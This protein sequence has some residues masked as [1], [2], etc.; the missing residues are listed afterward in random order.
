MRKSKPSAG[1]LHLP[2]SKSSA[3]AAP[4]PRSASS[5]PCA[6]I[7]CVASSQRRIL[8][9]L[10]LLSSQ[11]LV[12]K[13]I[14]LLHHSVLSVTDH[15]Q[16]Q[17]YLVSP[18]LINKNVETSTDSVPPYHPLFH[19]PH[20]QQKFWKREWLHSCCLH[21]SSPSPHSLCAQPNTASTC[22][23]LSIPLEAPSYRERPQ[24]LGWAVTFPAL[25]P[26][27]HSFRCHSRGGARPTC[28]VLN[29]THVPNR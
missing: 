8:P 21:A 27:P 9:C 24:A 29:R 6:S 17:K 23:V 10:L 3:W 20:S 7:L 1:V 2:T 11:R 18:I 26:P 25:T 13:I 16:Q 15:F 19:C 22:K 5:Y 14:P 28:K 4:P 12:F